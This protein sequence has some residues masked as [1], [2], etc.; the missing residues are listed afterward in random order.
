MTSWTRRSRPALIAFLFAVVVVLVKDKIDFTAMNSTKMTEETQPKLA[1]DGSDEEQMVHNNKNVTT[2]KQQQQQQ[3]HNLN[4][5]WNYPPGNNNDTSCF[6]L[7]VDR[8]QSTTKGPVTRW[9]FAGGSTMYRTFHKSPLHTYLIRK[10]YN[11]PCP[12]YS[13]HT[14]KAGRCKTDQLFGIVQ[15]VEHWQVPNQT[16]GPVGYGKTHPYCQ[17]CMGCDSILLHCRPDSQLS[18]CT[19]RT[20]PTGGYLSVEYARDVEIQST[21]HHTTQENFAHYLDTQWNTNDMV[22]DLG[23]PV[24]VVSTGVHDAKLLQINDEVY[25]GNVRS[26]LRLLAQQC[27]HVVWLGNTSPETNNYA[28]KIERTQR[29]NLAVLDLLQNND[30]FWNNDNNIMSPSSSSFVDVFE[31]STAVPHADN[32][33]MNHNWYDDLG[34]MFRK[35][36]E[37]VHDATHRRG[38]EGS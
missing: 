29:W 22:R 38:G 25:L 27:A 8:I 10:F 12:N 16:E 20:R 4:C 15:R 6:D 1:I 35:V 19:R 26:Y 28:Q 34:T 24:C 30:E 21:S 32:I 5:T 36:V 14:V 3:Q 9:I 2:A 17:D 11:P 23:R 7:L 33:H 18:A 13:C 31:A 37:E